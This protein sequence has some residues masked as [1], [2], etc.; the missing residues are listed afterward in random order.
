MERRQEIIIGI[1]ALGVR[2]EHHEALREVMV[3][4]RESGEVS[5]AEIYECALM[6][7]LFAGFPAALECA[8]ALK[9][10]WPSEVTNHEVIPAEDFSE[11]GFALY[12]RVYAGNA[13]RVRE[14]LLKLSPDLAEWALIEGYG[15]TLSRPGL[16]I[17]TREL[18]IVAMLSQ[19][20][21]NRQL[22]SHMMGALNVGAAAE[23]IRTALS[24]GSMHDETKLAHGLELLAKLT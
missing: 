15:K 19:L 12:Q 7:Y 16:D 22:Y 20:G 1:A 5:H 8:R 3:T 23:D 13:D 14:E 24:I 11:R 2:F 10:A 4:A 6:L 17:Q 21:W 9:K 18:A